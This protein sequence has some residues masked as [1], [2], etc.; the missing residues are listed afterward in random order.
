[1]AREPEDTGSRKMAPEERDFRE[2]VRTVY[3]GLR[4]EALQHRVTL[5][6]T[7]V[8]TMTGLTILL[9]AVLAFTGPVSESVYGFFPSFDFC[10]ANC[11]LPPSTRPA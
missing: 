4:S 9:A 10:S 11:E 1:M 6:Q 8:L 7:F 5:F 3:A 2:M